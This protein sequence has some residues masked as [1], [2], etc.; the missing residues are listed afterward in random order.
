MSKY[1]VIKRMEISGAHRL[2]LP[3][4]SK[5]RGLH[6]HNRIITVFCESETLDENG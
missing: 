5:C 6:G 3:Y 2:S 4:E 1:R